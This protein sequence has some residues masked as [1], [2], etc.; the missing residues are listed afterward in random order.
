MSEFQSDKSVTQSEEALPTMGGDS[1]PNDDVRSRIFS[2]SLIHD[3]THVDHVD[4]PPSC[5]SPFNVA[6]IFTQ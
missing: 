1:H 3:L 4:K 6:I 2:S 5:I